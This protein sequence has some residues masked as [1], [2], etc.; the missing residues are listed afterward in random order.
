MLEIMNTFTLYRILVLAFLSLLLPSHARAQEYNL[1][2]FLQYFRKP[3]SALIDQR[4]SFSLGLDLG[5]NLGVDREL[6]NG[7]LPPVSVGYDHILSKNIT[8]G[9][10]VEG[11][12]WRNPTQFAWYHYYT[13]TLRSAFHF[14]TG[15]QFWDPYFGLNLTTRFVG[16]TQGD[17]SSWN[18]KLSLNPVL[19]LRYFATDKYGA[20]VEFSSD[21]VGKISLGGVMRILP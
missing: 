12:N 20:F 3:A 18:R 5:S 4:A 1:D 7:I 2:S 16:L 8:V 13:G 14:D 19:G 9:L 10:M 15:S 21:G 17:F 6:F 11:Q